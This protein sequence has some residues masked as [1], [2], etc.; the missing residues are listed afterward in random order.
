MTGTVGATTQSDLGSV[1]VWSRSRSTLTKATR[2]KTMPTILSQLP[3]SL[4]EFLGGLARRLWVPSLLWS[5]CVEFSCSPFVCVASLQ[6]R[7]LTPTVQKHTPLDHLS[8][9]SNYKNV[10]LL[11][12]CA[13]L[14]CQHSLCKYNV[15]ELFK[16]TSSAKLKNSYQSLF[17]LL[18][19]FIGL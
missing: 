10:Q 19:E 16:G 15:R 5:F 9:L 18:R 11:Y 17:T 13:S 1:H 2:V 8:Q 3:E 6:L 7:Q 12:L 4:G 14:K